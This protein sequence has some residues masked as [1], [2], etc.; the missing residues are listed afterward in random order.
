MLDDSGADIGGYGKFQDS[1]AIP[2]S[3]Q[4]DE[5]TIRIPV[6]EEKKNNSKEKQATQENHIL[7]EAITE[8]SS[9]SSNSYVDR[10][11]LELFLVGHKI[12]LTKKASVVISS[13]D[14]SLPK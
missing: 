14:K 4:L 3:S 5:V 12:S 10:V 7:H 6:S 13:R 1:D 8:E 2:Q 9:H 11:R